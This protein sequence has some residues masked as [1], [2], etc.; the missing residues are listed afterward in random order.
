MIA[1]YQITRLFNYPISGASVVRR[2]RVRAGA[3][4]RG[5]V[6]IEGPARGRVD[7]VERHSRQEIGQAG[8]VVEP[9]AEEFPGLQKVRDGR[10]RFQSARDRADEIPPRVVQLLLRDA[11]ANQADDLFVDRCAGAIDVSRSDP[12]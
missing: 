7:L 9:E 5:P 6:W 11:V 1:D 8:I 3:N 12:G 4:D 2:A 10:V